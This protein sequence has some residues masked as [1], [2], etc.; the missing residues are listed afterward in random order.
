MGFKTCSHSLDMKSEVVVLGINSVLCALFSPV[1][2][3][4]FAPM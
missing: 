3:K 2:E 1:F 4:Y